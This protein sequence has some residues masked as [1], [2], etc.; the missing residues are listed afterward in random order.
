MT[1]RFSLNAILVLLIGLLSG[2]AFG[3]QYYPQQQQQPAQRYPQAAGPQRPVYQ[4]PA[5]RTAQPVAQPQ[6][7]YPRR[8]A[9]TVPAN[10]GAVISR[11][12]PTLQ[13]RNPALVN[14][15]FTPLTPAQ[16]AELDAVLKRWEEA[17]RKQKRITIEFNRFEFKPAF[18]PANKPK[19]PVRINQGKADFEA[20]GK[21]MWKVDREWVDGKSV[22][23]P[24][25]EHMVCDGQALYEFN[26]NDK[27]VTKH[28]MSDEMKNENMVRAMLPF[29][30]STDMSKLK[31]RY[32]LS[33]LPQSDPN[34][35]CIQAEP[36]YQNEAANFSRARMIL[37]L[38]KM[39]PTGMQI[40]LPNG[41]D[42]FSYQFIKVDINP[43]NPTELF[44]DPFK[45]K[46]PDGWTVQVDQLSNTE[47]TN[48][49]PAGPTR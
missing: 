11:N 18:A 5:Q 49:P 2:S 28:V 39:E 27:S 42:Y 7:T 41:S 22:E 9:Q 31:N 45:A 14:K 21:W 38:K 36:R 16:Q 23:S 35:V 4:Q 3:Q 30:F 25:T 20:S 19:D 26:E 15:A 24:V 46:I 48:R 43:R 6:Q 34:A 1:A 17:S 33:L 32:F 29:L 47:M 12:T 37:D 10:A 40:I 44:S 13:R 8:P